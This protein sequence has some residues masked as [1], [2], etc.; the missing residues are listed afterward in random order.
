MCWIQLYVSAIDV[1]VSNITVANLPYST[2]IKERHF[3]SHRDQNKERY[4]TEYKVCH[5]VNTSVATGFGKG[6]RF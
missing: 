5:F 3:A 6:I 4:V 2:D 1:K